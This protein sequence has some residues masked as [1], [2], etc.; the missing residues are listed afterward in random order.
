MI[1][2]VLRLV[3]ALVV[4]LSMAFGLALAIDLAGMTSEN[5]PETS[6]PRR[7]RGGCCGDC[8][9]HIRAGKHPVFLCTPRRVWFW[10]VV[11]AFGAFWF[12]QVLE[13]AMHLQ[14]AGGGITRCCITAAWAINAHEG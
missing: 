13:H 4:L 12:N 14:F 1:L 2:L 11:V 6:P 3:Y 9:A 10:L 5:L 8:A 7:R